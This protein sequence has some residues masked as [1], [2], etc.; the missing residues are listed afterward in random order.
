MSPDDFVT[1]RFKVAFTRGPFGH[2]ATAPIKEPKIHPK[3]AISLTPVVDPSS[4]PTLTRFLVLG[5]RLEQ[6]VRD[7]VV[8]DFTQLATIFGISKGRVTHLVNLTLLAPDI[9][10]QMLWLNIPDMRSPHLYER[11]L[12][13][14][15]LVVD[16]NHQTTLYLSWR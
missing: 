7:G 3:P 5:H 9:Q 11:S 14:L 15:T 10:E 16:W 4:V 2:K 12:R 8:Q 13:Q 1:M 6:L